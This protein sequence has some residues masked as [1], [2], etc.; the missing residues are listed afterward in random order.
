MIQLILEIEGYTV[1]QAATGREALAIAAQE[2]LDLVTIDLGLPDMSGDELSRRLREIPSLARCRQ[3]IVSGQEVD[4]ESSGRVDAVLSKPFDFTGFTEVLRDLLAQPTPAVILD[5]TAA[6]LDRI[7]T[8]RL[9]EPD[10]QPIVDLTTFEVVGVEAL[11]RGPHDSALHMPAALFAAALACGRL[12]E[13]DTLCQ[14]SA[15]TAA[16]AYRGQLP[17]R[18]FVNVDPGSFDAS[19]ADPGSAAAAS[20][21]QTTADL[22]QLVSGRL[23]LDRKSVV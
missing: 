19:W 2:P 18:V 5:D 7:L 21:L 15:L 8:G 12:P 20:A 4:A 9:I 3:M 10:F 1:H 17:P 22:W 16:C 23:P 13:L 11:A 6:E 14:L